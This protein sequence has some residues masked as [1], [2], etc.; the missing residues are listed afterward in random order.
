MVA[1]Y[2]G[3]SLPEGQG[4]WNDGQSRYDPHAQSQ[5][6]NQDPRAMPTGTRQMYTQSPP[7]DPGVTHTFSFQSSQEREQQL[8]RQNPPALDR[9][10]TDRD[11]ASSPLPPPGADR[12]KVTTT[13]GGS[14]RP[15]GSRI[16]GKC[17]EPLA[18]QFVRALDNTYHLDCFTCHVRCLVF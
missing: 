11:L 18:G 13:N 14:R 1:P 12:Q 2:A 6:S 15:S 8:T 4:N 9:Q 5:F 3:G 7:P 10:M 17:G 16:C